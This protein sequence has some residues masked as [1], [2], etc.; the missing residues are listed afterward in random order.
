MRDAFWR[1]GM[2]SRQN[3]MFAAAWVIRQSIK[4][5]P[6]YEPIDIAVLT[7]DKA[8]MLGEGELSYYMDVADQA[9]STSVCF[10]PATPPAPGEAKE[11]A[12]PPPPVPEP[13]K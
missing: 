10:D 4:V 13:P 5:A 2:P 7:G 9:T 3:G 6:G 11:P 8:R 12:L 1:D